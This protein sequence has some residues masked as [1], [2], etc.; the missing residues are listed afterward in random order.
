MNSAELNALIGKPNPTPGQ[1]TDLMLAVAASPD[2]SEEQKA[3][4]IL[5]LA[6]SARDIAAVE[7]PQPAP[8]AGPC[9]LCGGGTT[10]RPTCPNRDDEWN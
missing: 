2:L 3:M 9:F 8:P 10:C 7:A 1:I 5:A 6:D 4:T